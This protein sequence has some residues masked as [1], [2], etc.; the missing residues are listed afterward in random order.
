MDTSV[1]VELK[2]W[3]KWIFSLQFRL[4]SIE[5]AEFRHLVECCVNLCHLCV[6]YSVSVQLKK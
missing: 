2:T 6:I 4:K 3:N 5:N 1:N